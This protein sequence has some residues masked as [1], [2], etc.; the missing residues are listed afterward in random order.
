MRSVEGKLVHFTFDKGMDRSFAERIAP[1]GTLYTVKNM[2]ARNRETLKKRP[3]HSAIAGSV[4]ASTR[5]RIQ[6]NGTI[7]TVEKPSFITQ[8]GDARVLGITTGQVFALNGVDETRFHFQ[9]SFS[10][11]RPLGQGAGFASLYAGAASG[12]LWAPPCAAV[13]TSGYVMSAA[14]IG[15]SNGVH[16]QIEDP[17]GNRIWSFRL[18]GADKVQIAQDGETFV[19]LWQDG[20]DIA[21]RPITVSDGVVTVGTQRSAG[22]LASATAPWDSSGGR[23][24]LILWVVVVY[25]DGANQIRVKTIEP[26]GGSASSTTFA[27]TGDSPC[28]VWYMEAASFTDDKIWVGYYTDVATNGY[29][30]YRVYNGGSV[31]TSIL[32]ETDITSGVDTLGPPLFGRY[33]NPIDGVTTQETDALYVIRAEDGGTNGIVR[34]LCGV[35]YSGGSP[36]SPTSIYHVLPVSKPDD[37]GRFWGLV[38]STNTGLAFQRYAL[39]R[40]PWSLPTQFEGKPVIELA[41]PEFPKFEADDPTQTWLSY[42]YFHSAGR[43]ASQCAFALNVNLIDVDESPLTRAAVYRYTVG[44]QA[45]RQ[46]ALRAGSVAIAAGQPTELFGQ[47]VDQTNITGTGS[48]ELVGGAAEIGFLHA[49]VILSATQATGSG[50]APGAYQY[51]AVFQYADKFGRRHLSQPSPPVSVTVTADDQVDVV[52]QWLA[53]TQREQTIS[54]AAN[55]MLVLLYRTKN[56]GTEYHLVGSNSGPSGGVLTI[57]DTMPDGDMSDEQILYTDGGVLPN[58]LAPSCRFTAFSEDRLWCGGLWDENV[59]ECSKIIVPGEPLLFTGDPTHQVYL[60]AKCTGLA[61]QDG[62]L[63]AFC[64]DEIYVVSGDGPNDQGIGSFPSPRRYA[65]GV[66]CINELSVV[67]TNAGIYFQGRRGI[68][69]IPRGFGAVEFVGMAVGDLASESDAQCLGSCAY[70]SEDGGQ[71]VK[72]L[73]GTPGSD[74]T[75]SYVL[76]HDTDNGNWYQDTPALSEQR[77]IGA[78]NGSSVLVGDLDSDDVASPI[79]IESSSTTQDGGSNVVQDVQTGWMYPFGPGGWGRVNHVLVAFERPASEATNGDISITVETDNNTAQ[80]ATFTVTGTGVQYR[81]VTVSAQR[82]NSIR[83]RVYDAGNHGYRLLGCTLEVDDSQGIRP[84]HDGERL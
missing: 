81:Y 7:S 22:T 10:T 63:A 2:R 55:G 20:T 79:W 56:G 38:D 1:P 28:S 32:G 84:P 3:G 36:G 43:N 40:V 50:V 42:S 15:N 69:R 29:V 58:V 66:G 26:V 47:P 25:Q 82:C 30:R 68:Y 9:G 44:D 48:A 72:W 23:S 24:S 45:C 71:L 41:S 35:A 17:D 6:G 70:E 61:Y 83:V 60:P 13:N 19:L 53:T 78:W 76:V 75:G 4:T 49:P 59:L 46:H 37:Y 5:A 27:V 65:V 77:A 73:F 16:A 54:A 8:A 34:T 80:T 39:L 64:K 31:T 21:Y 74:P 11:A 12:T 62:Q 18:S 67:T 33:Y 51:R 14:I 57:T 52:I